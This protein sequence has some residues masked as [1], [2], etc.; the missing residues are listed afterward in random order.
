MVLVAV[1]VVGVSAIQGRMFSLMCTVSA[2]DSSA[3]LVVQIATQI[4]IISSF[5]SLVLLQLAEPYRRHHLLFGHNH[6]RVCL[7]WLSLLVRSH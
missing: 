4:I 6:T 5:V 7:H 1:V 3:R 2:K